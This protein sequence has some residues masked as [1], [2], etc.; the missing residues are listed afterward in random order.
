MLRRRWVRRVAV[1]NIPGIAWRASGLLD[2]D[3]ES[4]LQTEC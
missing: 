4:W 1:Y 2:G 3:D